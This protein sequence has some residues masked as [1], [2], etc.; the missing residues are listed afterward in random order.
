MRNGEEGGPAG[1]GAV[2][3]GVKQWDDAPVMLLVNSSGPARPNRS[4]SPR[5]RRSPVQAWHGEPAPGAA[6]GVFTDEIE[7]FGVRVY[8]TQAQS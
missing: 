4:I 6:A 3:V 8:S 1:G 2:A 5:L 7:P